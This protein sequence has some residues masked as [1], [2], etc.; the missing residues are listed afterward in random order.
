LNLP[1]PPRIIVSCNKRDEAFLAQVFDTYKPRNLETLEAFAISELA[2]EHEQDPQELAHA[3]RERQRK[4]RDEGGAGCK[5]LPE[6]PKHPGDNDEDGDA[7]GKATRHSG[8]GGAVR[9]AG[10]PAIGHDVAFTHAQHGNA[11]KRRGLGPTQKQL[12][13]GSSGQSNAAN[14]AQEGS[15][16]MREL[17]LMHSHRQRC[18]HTWS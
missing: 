6:R 14:G 8:G 7:Q 15:A 10:A 18:R 16:D 17:V 5:P 9:A 1:A 4:Q 13:A 11:G 12:H 2:E 3:I